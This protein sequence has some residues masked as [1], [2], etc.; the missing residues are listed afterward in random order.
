MNELKQ[1][2][3]E[4]KENYMVCGIR[5]DMASEIVPEQEFVTFKRLS[6]EFGLKYNIKIGGCDSLTDIS[7]AKNAG[8]DSIICPMI[9]TEYAVQKFL[10]HCKQVYKNLDQVNLFINIETINAYNNLDSILASENMKSIT[11]IV[12]GRDDIAAS[13]SL[14]QDDVNSEQIF[15][16]AS[17]ISNKA[18]EYDKTF[19]IGGGIRPQAIHF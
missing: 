8:A 1:I 12:L 11:G 10:N 17:D 13:L 6:E 15:N 18:G 7:S 2:L 4:L 19:T 14:N 9:E 16:I 3:K 5:T